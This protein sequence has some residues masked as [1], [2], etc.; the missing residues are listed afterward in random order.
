[1]GCSLVRYLDSTLALFFS[2]KDKRSR[3]RKLTQKNLTDEQYIHLADKLIVEVSKLDPKYNPDNFT[4]GSVITARHYG[5][6]TYKVDLYFGFNK[7]NNSINHKLPITESIA[8]L[9][10][11][12][13]DLKNRTLLNKDVISE[14]FLDDLV[15]TSLRSGDDIVPKVR[16]GTGKGLD[17]G[18]GANR[19]HALVEKR[20]AVLSPID[21]Q[22]ILELSNKVENFDAFESAFNTI[23]DSTE[24]KY[25]NPVS[26]AQKAFAESAAKP[27][28]A[29]K[30][31][32]FGDPTT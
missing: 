2:V 22:A 23:F 30:G 25:R 11:K 13:L 21:A 10:F 18:I 20:F 27:K 15:T 3:R 8:F 24:A 12:A 7:T 31:Y 19:V 16:L 14:S 28:A 4:G 9:A 5:R 32:F 6:I 1:M 29:K 17:K 26:I